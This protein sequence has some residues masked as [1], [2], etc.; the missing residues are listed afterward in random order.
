MFASLTRAAGTFFFVWHALSEKTGFCMFSIFWQYLVNIGQYFP[1]YIYVHIYIYYVSWYIYIYIYSWIYKYIYIY[2]CIYIS[3]NIYICIYIMKHNIYIYEHRYT[4][5]NIDQYWPNIVKKWKTYKNLFF[6]KG[7][8]KQ[9]KKCLR[10][11]SAKQTWVGVTNIDQIL[12]N[13]D[14]YCIIKYYHY[15]IGHLL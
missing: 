2:I 12:I 1:G 6:P 11:W 15:W 14:K 9:K 13:I 5:E 10:L 8:V 7:H 3:K 4:Q